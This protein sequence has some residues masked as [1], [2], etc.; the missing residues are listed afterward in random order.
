MIFYVYCIISLI[1]S[2]MYRFVSKYY[3]SR[4][5]CTASNFFSALL[6]TGMS[7]ASGG[8]KGRGGGG[9][10]FEWT[11]RWLTENKIFVLDEPDRM[12]RNN[13]FCNLY[14]ALCKT[15]ND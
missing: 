7:S 6:S 5:H 2:F 1:Y 14:D 12:V 13:I 9:A 10:R 11:L 8:V 3:I 4:N 15:G